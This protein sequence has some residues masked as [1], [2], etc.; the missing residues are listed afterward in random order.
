MKT[1]AEYKAARAKIEDEWAKLCERNDWP[2]TVDNSKEF[3][4]FA[5]QEIAKTQEIYELSQEHLRSSAGVAN[6]AFELWLYIALVQLP[7]V[8]M[9]RSNQPNYR[10]QNEYVNEIFSSLLRLGVAWADGPPYPELTSR[11]VV[12]T[13]TSIAMR[14]EQ[15][16][17]EL[18]GNGKGTP[19]IYDENSVPDEYRDKET[20]ELLVATYLSGHQ[21]W[22]LKSADLSRAATNNN[23]VTIK[24]KHDG[25]RKKAY[26]YT[27]IVAYRAEK[28]RRGE[29]DEDNPAVIAARKAEIDRKKGRKS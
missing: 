10:S 23:W 28:T 13:L 25:K 7:L 19:K 3:N 4:E 14:L 8:E 17:A 5:Q 16:E 18:R 21:D 12:D 26:R 11:E 27:D 2:P 6:S 9:F 24:V 15:D 22:L 1:I 20:G 29:R